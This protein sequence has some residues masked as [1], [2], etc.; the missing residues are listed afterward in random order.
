MKFFI[1]NISLITVSWILIVFSLFKIEVFSK[2]IYIGISLGFLFALFF[3]LS[4]FLLYNFALKR[5]NK[6]FLRTIV[7]SIFCRLLCI[8]GLLFLVIKYMNID[9]RLFFLSLFIWYFI[10]QILEIVS[11]NKLKVKGS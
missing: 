7:S 9:L 3:V 4:G 10:F 1:K 8:S 11:F 6:I 2:D 5:A